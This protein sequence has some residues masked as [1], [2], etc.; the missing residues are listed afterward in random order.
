[1]ATENW[2]AVHKKI[3]TLAVNTRSSC[4]SNWAPKS[5]SSGSGGHV[6]T[7]WE[8]HRAP[9]CVYMCRKHGTRTLQFSLFSANGQ[10][11]HGP[12]TQRKSTELE[13]S[14]FDNFLPPSCSYW[15]LLS[16]KISNHGFSQVPQLHQLCECNNSQANRVQYHKSISTDQKDS[17]IVII[18]LDSLL[19][20]R[21]DI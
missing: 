12:C 8:P 2:K 16:K 3:K 11:V 14:S 7:H 17:E 13:R 1:M 21:R 18:L 19:L 9:T 10:H 6:Q 4:R 20:N 15:V 5:H